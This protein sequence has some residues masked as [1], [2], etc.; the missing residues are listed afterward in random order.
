MKFNGFTLSEIS[1]GMLLGS[2]I[3]V[4]GFSFLTFLNQS[5]FIQV[6]SFERIN[7]IK[8]I[9]AIISKNFRIYDPKLTE[10]N[11]ITFSSKT[12]E[13]ESSLQLYPDSII[14]KSGKVQVFNLETNFSYRL[15]DSN[16]I[17]S[18]Q[19]EFKELNEH[20]F[21]TFHKEYNNG[22][23]IHPNND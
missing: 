3:V 19:L 16:L 23:L 11:T 22:F 4:F 12:N 2:L 7:D 13:I 20:T 5:L 10:G 17:D 8:M 9:Q 6:K 18:F 21:L 1:I 15:I 14:Y